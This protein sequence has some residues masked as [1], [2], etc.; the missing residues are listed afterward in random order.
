M[1]SEP[2]VVYRPPAS[3]RFPTQPDPQNAK[4]TQGYDHI[5]DFLPFTC[6]KSAC[7]N[8]LLLPVLYLPL[9]LV[10]PLSVYP[11]L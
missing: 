9:S 1:S 6:I 11:F 4:I 7:V 3:D 10:Y 2:A 5:R 8:L